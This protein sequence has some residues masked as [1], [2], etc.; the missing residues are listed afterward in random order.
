MNTRVAATACATVMLSYLAALGVSTPFWVIVSTTAIFSYIVLACGDVL[1]RAFR[2]TDMSVAASWALG[3]FATALA[4]AGV[5]LALRCTAAAAFCVWAVL[6]LTLDFATR[7]RE[8]RE[9]ISSTQDSIGFLFCCAFTAAWCKD[10]AA[11]PKI[12]QHTGQFQPW[13]EYFMHAGVIS[14]FGDERAIGRG[15][16]WLV[17]TPLNLYHYASYAVA[18]TFALPLNEPGLSIATSV[19][20]PLG[21][22][23]ASTAAYTLG[24]CFA[25]AA[26]G[27]AA[28]LAVLVLPDPSN[29]G[30]RNGFF[31]FHWILAAIPASPYGLASALLAVAFLQR[32]STERTRH[33][34][35]ASA[36]LVAA[37][38][39][40][41]MQ[42][43][44][45]LAPAWMACV[46]YLGRVHKHPRILLIIFLV[47]AI[48]FSLLLWYPPNLPSSFTWAIDGGRALEGFLFQ[49]HRRQEPTAY[50]GLYAQ[51]LSAFG[52]EIG[53]AL[54]ALLVY[55]ICLGAFL[56]ALPF[57]YLM[58]SR[59]KLVSSIAFPVALL[60]W[61]GMVM[62]LAPIPAHGD[63]TE[64]P[65]RSFL[66]LYA[67]I[68]IWTV[69]LS[70]RLLSATG[71]H[72]YRL[73]QTI[74]VA[75]MVAL[76]FT[77]TTAAKLAYPK[78]NWARLWVNYPVQHEL[79][80]ASAI[81]RTRSEP[82]D[83]F[84]MPT[85][86]L[87]ITSADPQTIVVALTG[88][89]SYLARPGVQRMLGG[90]YNDVSSRRFHE[91]G[92]VEVASDAEAALQELRALGIRW[93]LV[94]DANRPQWD[95]ERTRTAWSKG[96]VALYDSRAVTALRR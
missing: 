43:F 28:L 58:H 83:V 6:V 16:I 30:M 44:V 36:S 29:Y 63:P 8:V 79:L 27:L 96:P 38:L 18:A 17:D 66:L 14:E 26:G 22:L 25:G 9:A 48:A 23:T 37:T 64:Y 50:Q 53:Y 57:A 82:G 34:L 21:F 94:T 78:P 77:W 89:P 33:A 75:S 32:W 40:V 72:G 10:V 46:A 55:P 15:M 60:V 68:A 54:G 71:T 49:V 90:I 12:L 80:A 92:A 62:A 35:V 41:R 81:L 4:L 84:A 61:F 39:L 47:L 19:W 69:G 88:V 31:S 91:L 20:L 5:V 76:P 1:L 42:V 95:P 56:I 85:R 24:T 2:A 70:I 11:A 3:L 45:L 51:I 59:A 73:W 87:L 74:V 7:R 86:Q 52:E 93:Y 67:T 65:H 13:V